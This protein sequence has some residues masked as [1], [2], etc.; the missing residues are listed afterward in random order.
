MSLFDMFKPNLELTKLTDLTFDQ[1]NKA[2]IKLILIDIDNTLV[3]WHSSQVLPENI[4]WINQGKKLGYNFCLISNNY[5]SSR[6]KSI[7]DQTGIPYARGIIK[8]F[9]MMFKQALKMYNSQPSEAVMIGDQL[10]TDV[11]GANRSGIMS[12]WV[13]PLSQ[14]EFFSTKISRFFER[15]VLKRKK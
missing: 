10:F 3:T 7:S 8:P 11:L 2:G 6:L 9:K 1:L 15:L 14:K 13:Q 12:V 4:E 5:F